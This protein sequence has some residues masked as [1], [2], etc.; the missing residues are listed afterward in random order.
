MPHTSYLIP[1][2]KDPSDKIYLKKGRSMFLY[3]ILALLYMEKYDK[4]IQK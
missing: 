2:I 3:Q 4:G 1:H